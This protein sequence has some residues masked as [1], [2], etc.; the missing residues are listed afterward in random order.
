MKFG[1]CLGPQMN[2]NSESS[3]LVDDVHSNEMNHSEHDLIIVKN[4]KN[5]L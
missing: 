3:E 5:L 2:H 4:C 1:E